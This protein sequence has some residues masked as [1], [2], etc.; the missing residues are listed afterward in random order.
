MIKQNYGLK[1]RVEF[2]RNFIN[3]V[4][5]F[6]YRTIAIG[7]AF[8]LE[9]ML[10]KNIGAKIFQ[11]TCIRAKSWEELWTNYKKVLFIHLF[12]AHK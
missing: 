12:S 4:N 5:S 2:W 9:W 7:T 6:C 8:I 3:F 10:I 1:M 11:I